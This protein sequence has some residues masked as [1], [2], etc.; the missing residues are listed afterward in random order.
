MAE[1]RLCDGSC[2]GADLGPLLDP[3]LRWLWQQVAAAADRRGDPEL[4][5]GQALQVRAPQEVDGRA[6]AVGLLGGALA[7]GQRRRVA[8]DQLTE[9]LRHRGVALTPG[10]VAAHAL[11]RPLAVD[12]LKRSAEVERR[13]RLIDRLAEQLTVGAGP[14]RGEPVAVAAAFDRSRA[15][16]MTRTRSDTDPLVGAAVRV[17]RALPVDGRRVDRRMLASS[18]LTGPHDLD[19]DQPVAQ[20]VRALLTAGGLVTPGT[21]ARDAWSVV[22]VDG[23]E[24]T[25]G[26]VALGIHPVGWRLPATAI[27]TLPPV[28]LVDCR[29]PAPEQTSTRVF[30]TE[31]PSVLSAARRLVRADAPVRLLCTSGTPSTLE[32]AAIA[33]L[34]DAGWEVAVRADFDH[35]GLAHVTALLNAAPAAR[36]WRMSV[37]DY[38]SSVD[39]GSDLRLH[40]PDQLSSPWEPAL[41]VAMRRIGTPAFEEALLPALLHDL[42][43]GR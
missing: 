30:V 27:A 8:L 41:A 33:R 39:A 12:A 32:A 28:E 5:Q 25:G 22:G 31:N 40:R 15:A 20:V 4:R 14:L 29:W 6:A 26:L 1:C 2:V 16:A 21:R 34:A 7:P 23:D 3:A 36:L 9:R 10:A 19:D 17:V 24:L 37:D 42:M 13:R 18:V 38:V 35:A 11:D 43:T